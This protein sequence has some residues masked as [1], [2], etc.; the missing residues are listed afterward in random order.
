MGIGFAIMGMGTHMVTF[1]LGLDSYIS[2]Q[3]YFLFLLLAIYFGMRGFKRSRTDAG[4]KAMF[5]SGMQGG[6]IFTLL[7]TA[8]TYVYYQW[9]NPEYFLHRIESRVAEASQLG[10]SEDQ[11]EKVRSTAMFIFSAG[12]DSTVNL[13]MF[14]L[15]TVLYSVTIAILFRRLPMLWER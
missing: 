11:I 13:I 1:F 7:V 10:Y 14:M 12:V 6:A 15:M 4:F 8:F 9:L 2:T 3:L 5:R